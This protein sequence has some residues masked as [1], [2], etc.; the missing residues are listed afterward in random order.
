MDDP[1]A[2]IAHPYFPDLRY[3]Q[4]ALT[5]TVFMWCALCS[6]TSNGIP[7]RIARAATAHVIGHRCGAPLKVLFQNSALN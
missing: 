4:V 5:G 7:W 2:G 6:A 1:R 3:H